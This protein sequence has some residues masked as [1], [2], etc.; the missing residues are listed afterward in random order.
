MNDPFTG[1]RLQK[2]PTQT[3][4]GPLESLVP[5]MSNPFSIPNQVGVP[6][7]KSLTIRINPKKTASISETWL[8]PKSRELLKK[9]EGLIYDLAMHRFP[10]DTPQ[11][12]DDIRP[13]QIKLNDATVRGVTLS[14]ELEFDA[15]GKLAKVRLA[16]IFEGEVDMPFDK[17]GMQ[18]TLC[19]ALEERYGPPDERNN[20][21]AST[22]V[23]WRFPNTVI[24]CSSSE[25]PKGPG[26]VRKYVGIAYEVPTEENAQGKEKL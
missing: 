10:E 1:E 25:F 21:A 7:Q 19:N 16:N 24:R 3:V 6:V 13:S 4:A 20:T 18:Q 14:P 17:N 12:S 8:E 5:D 9:I 23:I 26:I 11:A 22:H 15:D 2:G